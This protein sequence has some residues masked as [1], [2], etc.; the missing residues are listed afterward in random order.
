MNGADRLC[1]TLLANDVDVCFA[2]PGT[3]EMHFV[4]AL[5]RKPRIRCVL[6]LFEGVVT[7]AADGYARMADK[8]AA[9]LL[10]TGPGLANGLANIHNARRA[11]TPMI[12]IVGDHAGYHL[13][14]DA[15]LTSD[16]E[17]LARPM[18]HWVRRIA[19]S[20]TIERDVGEAY[21]AAMRLPG[22]ATLILPADSA[23]GDAPA[24]A[25][26]RTA[27]PDLPQVPAEAVRAAAE[28]V[29]SG[30]RTALMMTG[31]ALRADALAHA[32]RI[33]AATGV[34]LWCQQ[35]N[36]RVERGA[37]RVPVN[38]VPY[39]V[40]LALKAL[41]HIEVMILVGA[42]APVAFFAYPGKPS[43]M[44]AEGCR[45]LRLAEPEQDLKGALAWLADELGIASNIAPLAA[46]P[47]AQGAL[48][49]GPLNADAINVAVARMMPPNAIL[50]DESVTSGRRF[51]DISQGSA[52]HDFIQ[53]TGGAIGE[54][55]PL[56]IGA[57][58]ACPDRKVVALQADGSGMYTIQGLW[59]QARENLD[60][61]TVVFANSSYA[62]LQG[63][64]RGVGVNEI[65]RNAQRM[66]DLDSPKLD[67]V[68]MAKGMGVEA[69]RATTVA[70]FVRLFEG[71]SA[72]RG[73]FL[74]E[75][76]I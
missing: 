10:H 70:E 42:K 26:Q 60:V 59:T 32:G 62:I 23:W 67:W 55:I 36:G 8:P 66:L 34:E 33:A 31:A 37:G 54:G 47:I 16:I 64:M 11:R 24:S 73:P 52:P 71:A 30:K 65:G 21:Q 7:G 14:Y 2:N 76:V 6:G 13:Q 27:L 5:D 28:A 75:A 49:E 40:D 50:V 57:A 35:S 38:R 56:A 41:S 51:F 3:S 69:A 22:I 12:N 39:P 72:G 4:A 45:I 61:V 18:S 46:E 63:E 19:S 29:R 53:L 9:T 1:D 74:I 25:V 48:P 68:S 58:F 17:S 15:P 43:V 20:G 44:T